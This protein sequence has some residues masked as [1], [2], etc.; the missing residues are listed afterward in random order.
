MIPTISSISWL[1]PIIHIAP[2]VPPLDLPHCSQHKQNDERKH[3]TSC[4]SVHETFQE[5]V[6]AISKLLAVTSDDISYYLRLVHTCSSH[7]GF[8][9]VL[10]AGQHAAHIGRVLTLVGVSTWHNLSPDI[11]VRNFLPSLFK[12]PFVPRYSSLVSPTLPLSSLRTHCSLSL[13]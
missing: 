8:H 13:P 12:C 4:H 11:H 3:I 1:I 10:G 7:I 6:I 5:G 2:C 9:P